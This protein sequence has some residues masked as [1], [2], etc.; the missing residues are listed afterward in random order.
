MK[1]FNDTFRELSNAIKH[2]NNFIYCMG[3]YNI[4]VLN[5]G[6]HNEANNLVDILH[7][8]LASLIN[9][10]TRAQKES[11]KSVDNTFTNNHSKLDN[12]FQRLIYTDS[13][14]HFPTIHIEYNLNGI[15]PG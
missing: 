3:N 15:C 13:T 10:N 12:A 6:K 1:L 5:H 2:E 9:C 11:V 4:K 14:D 7:V 8:S